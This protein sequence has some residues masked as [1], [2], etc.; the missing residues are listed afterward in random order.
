MTIITFLKFFN[1][2]AQ[3][4]LS[5]SSRRFSQKGSGSSW[6]T[7]FQNVRQPTEF[8][9]HGVLLLVTHKTQ[10]TF[11]IYRQSPN[12]LVDHDQIFQLPKK[13][14]KNW[15]KM[16]LEKSSPTWSHFSRCKLLF[17]NELTRLILCQKHGIFWSS[18]GGKR[19]AERE[20]HIFH[21]FCQN[22]RYL[23]YCL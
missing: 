16:I 6:L 19:L 21:Q 17:Y 20:I 13:E 3:L 7:L 5:Y 11:F 2:D 15:T 14:P 12:V 4:L 9:H 22:L 18:F 23:K 10:W 1:S 8:I